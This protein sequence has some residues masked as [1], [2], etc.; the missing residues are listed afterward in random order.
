[1]ARAASTAN[2]SRLPSPDRAHFQ[3][4]DR[5]L[6]FRPIL[7]NP[8]H[9]LDTGIDPRLGLGGGFLDAQLRDPGPDGFGHAAERLDLFDV[10][11]SAARELVGE[12]LDI[13]RAAPRIDHPRGPGFLL[14]EQLGVARD[15]GGKIRRQRQRLVERIGMQR[16]GVALGRRHRLDR[17]AHHVVECVLRGE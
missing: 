11:P 10:S 12:A 1:L 6:G 5:P 4:L 16:L 15:P 3:H 2:A 14:Q 8:D 9:R 17:G 7:V 13:E